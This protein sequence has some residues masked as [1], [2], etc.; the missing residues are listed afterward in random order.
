MI[1]NLQSISLAAIAIMIRQDWKKVSFSAIPY[2][3]AMGQLQDI[4]QDYGMDTGKMVVAY[5]LGNAT[6]WRGE[7]AREIK[8]ELNRRLKL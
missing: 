2:L 4:H 8:E 7:I 5:F 3:N 1:E 6:T